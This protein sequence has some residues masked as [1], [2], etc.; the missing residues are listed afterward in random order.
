M[1]ADWNY[2]CSIESIRANLTYLK[3]FDLNVSGSSLPPFPSRTNLT[4]NIIAAKQKMVKKVTLA[5]DFAKI[6][7]PD[8]APVVVL[9]NPEPD[10]L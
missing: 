8:G 5:L 4:L 1:D 7:G 6:S 3:N 2:L 10:L 9:K